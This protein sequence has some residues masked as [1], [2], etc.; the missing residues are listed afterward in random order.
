M[1]AF[2]LFFFLFP[3]S[4][5][6]NIAQVQA[7]ARAPHGLV[8][9]NPIAFSP[10]AFDFFHP[11]SPSPKTDEPCDE[12]ECAPMAAQSTF[13]TSSAVVRATPAH[14][15]RVSTSQSSRRSIGAGGIAGIVFGF[16]FAVLLAIGVYYV[17]IT[18]RT[19]LNRSNSVQ[20]DV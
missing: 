8:F 19:N 2:L 18:R 11:N 16:V 4:S 6:Y 5:L 1:A 7:Q 15:S 20:P 17:M 10:S 14:E 3:L 12:S 9:E 13:S